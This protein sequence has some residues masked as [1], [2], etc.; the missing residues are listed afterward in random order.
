M[1]KKRVFLGLTLEELKM[2]KFNVITEVFNGVKLI[3]TNPI[4]DE[5]GYFQRLFCLDELKEIGLSKNI[6]NIN[7]SLTKRAGSIRG[8][9]YQLQPFSETKIVK[10]IKGAILDVAIDIRKNSPTFLQYFATEL[11]EK[12]NRILF[13][14]EGFA[15]AF[16]SLTNDTEIIYFVTNYYSKKHESGLNP[17]DTRINIAWALECTDISEKDKNAKFI[18]NNFIGIDL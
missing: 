13:I 7:H 9:H 8:L 18:D 14:P 11:T 4:K 16:Q 6:V 15:H 3:E 10:C 1:Q 12:N 5:R 17:F 2:N